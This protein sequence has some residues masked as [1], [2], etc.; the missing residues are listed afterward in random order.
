MARGLTWTVFHAGMFFMTIAPVSYA[1]TRGRFA[2]KQAL[3]DRAAGMSLAWLSPPSED[4]HGN[5]R[6]RPDPPAL[7]AMSVPE[8]KVS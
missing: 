6:L 8:L 3:V 1:V 4:I 2:R 7:A 5:I